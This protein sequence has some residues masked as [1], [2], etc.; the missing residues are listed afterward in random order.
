MWGLESKPLP[1]KLLIAIIADM[2][3]A[4][5]LIPG[6]DLIETPVNAFVAYALTDNPKALAVGAIDGILPTPFD[7]FPSATVIVIADEM[8][9]I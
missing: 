2:A 7:F 6:S 3:D 8:G 5:N 4:L 1:I 9:W